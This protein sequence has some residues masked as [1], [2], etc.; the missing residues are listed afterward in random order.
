MNASYPLSSGPQSSFSGGF[1]SPITAKA[2]YSPVS[3]SSLSITAVTTLL[4]YFPL[5]LE[6]FW[7][8]VLSFCRHIILCCYCIWIFHY[9]HLKISPLTLCWGSCKVWTDFNWWLG[10]RHLTLSWVTNNPPRR[11]SCLVFLPYFCIW[12]GLPL[13]RSPFHSIF[14]WH[15]YLPSQFIQDHFSF[16]YPSV[17]VLWGTCWSPFLSPQFDKSPWW[18]C[19]ISRGSLGQW[20]P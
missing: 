12:I 17:V 16:I 3:S 11:S 13:A 4:E 1:Y 10:C 14:T 8:S 5:F 18:G 19:W 6:K 20:P 7:C 2:N 15:P 9:K